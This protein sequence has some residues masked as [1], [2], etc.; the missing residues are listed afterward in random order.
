MAIISIIVP[1]YNCEK[2][3][4]RCIESICNQSLSDIE[5]IIVDDGSYDSSGVICDELARCDSRMHVIH[6]DNGGV[7][8]ARN[9]GLAI[10]TGKYVMFC[11]GDDC[12][13]QDCCKDLYILMQSE[14]LSFAVCKYK[15]VPE[16]Y[17]YLIENMKCVTPRSEVLLPENVITICSMNLIKSCWNKIFINKIIKENNIKFREDLSFNEDLLF[18]IDYMMMSKGKIG[19]VDEELYLYRQNVDNSLSHQYV[20]R[21]WDLKVL[22]ISQI[23]KLFRYYGVSEDIIQETITIYWG[24]PIVDSISYI[25]NKKNTAK[26][27]DKIKMIHLILKS[28][29]CT[30]TFKIWDFPNISRKYK[31]VL[32]TQ[33]A[34][35]VYI[36]NVMAAF[37][38]RLKNNRNSDSSSRIIEMN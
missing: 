1:V 16:D 15:R 31:L 38:S 22:T 33:N 10:S 12:L 3:V 6:K 20:P 27:V 9:A 37:T 17:N 25:L 11:D 36:Y 35:I 23:E 13:T 29:Q 19:I 26:R 4:G 30:A 7:S 24:W 32:K 34:I 21:Y 5:I 28:N 14:A 8:S 18:V 2:Y